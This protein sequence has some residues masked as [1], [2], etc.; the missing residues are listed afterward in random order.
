M[1]FF[2]KNYDL[3]KNFFNDINLYYVVNLTT[4]YF[5]TITDEIE[6]EIEDKL[7]DEDIEEDDEIE[8]EN[9]NNVNIMDEEI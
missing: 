9:N 5:L 7:E 3:I 8:E 2:C 4:T 6:E 1:S